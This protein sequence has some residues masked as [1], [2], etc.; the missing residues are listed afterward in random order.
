MQ[1]II[2]TN[3]RSDMSLGGRPFVACAFGNFTSGQIAFNEI[4]F[5]PPDDMEF[6]TLIDE[7][8]VSIIRDSSKTKAQLFDGH[9]YKYISH[10]STEMHLVIEIA[11]TSY[12]RYIGS[13]Y[14]NSHLSERF[15]WDK[16]SNPIGISANVMSSDGW[17][18]YGRRSHGVFTHRGYIQAFGGWLTPED[19]DN[20]GTIDVFAAMT[21][22]LSE[23][24]LLNGSEIHEIKCLGLIK[25]IN[26]N[27]YELVFDCYTSV[28]KDELLSRSASASFAIEH[29]FIESFKDDPDAAKEFLLRSGPIAPVGVGA[30]CFHGKAHYGEEWYDKTNFP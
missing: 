18:I 6:D 21:R 11:P 7:T 23:E 19:V 28:T 2:T 5:A 14:I 16:F 30:I 24:L 27:Q 25:S 15:G 13:N 10:L 1:N 12:S 26:T 20:D 3:C 8:W 29:S 9:L 22:E 17:C 4:N